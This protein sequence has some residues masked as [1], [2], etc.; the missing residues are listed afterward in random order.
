[1]CTKSQ[2][3]V[4]LALNTGEHVI[5]RQGRLFCADWL[6]NVLRVSCCHFTVHNDLIFV[7]PG[8]EGVHKIVSNNGFDKKLNYHIINVSVIIRVV[9]THI[10]HTILVCVLLTCVRNIFAVVL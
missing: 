2:E 10:A 6:K 1:M 4:Y 3:N 7:T 8:L 9:F 5:G